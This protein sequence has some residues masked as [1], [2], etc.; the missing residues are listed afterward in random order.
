MR[1]VAA[2]TGFATLLLSAA[3][4][5]QSEITV[6]TKIKQADTTNPKAPPLV[7]PI[8]ESVQL[9]QKAP[10]GTTAPE[11]CNDPWFGTLNAK[12]KLALVVGKSKAD[13][14]LPD[15]LWMDL[16][17]DGKF[18]A[19]EL[20]KLE[21]TTSEARG[22]KIARSK[23]VNTTVTIDGTKLS[24]RLAFNKAGERPPFVNVSFLDYL[25][26][27]VKIGTEE[28]IL[29]IQDKDLDGKF[30]GKDDLWALAKPGDKQINANAMSSLGEHRFENGK[31]I[32]IKLDGTGKVSMSLA[33]ANGP[34]P[35]DAASHRHRIEKM[36]SDRFDLER[37]DFVKQRGLDTKRPK[38]T[39]EIEW[40]YVS[41]DDAIALGKKSGKPVFVDVMAFWCVWCYRMDYYTYPDQEVAELLNTKFVPVKLIQEQDAA[42]DYKRLMELLEAKGIPAMGIFD[43][44]GKK[45]HTI[46]GW[47]KPEDFV[48]ELEIGLK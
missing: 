8:T 25:E 40:Q 26:A 27:N 20:L 19:N 47:K 14:E 43:G 22:T 29:A 32:G 30:G 46:S 45:V 10:A 36:W 12:K 3:I 7:Q 24:A 39:K 17:G 1:P 31:S 18:A 33:D 42:N 9:V 38:A 41:F 13:A 28:H 21:V 37:E 23:P 34:D 15:A 16:D 6:F 2:R 44:E 35:K 4:F 48:K 11:E 5:A